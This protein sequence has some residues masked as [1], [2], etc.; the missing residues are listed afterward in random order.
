MK[1]RLITG[2]IGALLFL[3]ILYLGEFPYALLILMLALIGYD[4]F[5][6]MSGFK[7]TEGIAWTGYGLIL[8]WFSSSL[9]WLPRAFALTFE[10]ITWFTVFILLTV[11]VLSKNRFHF[12]RVA[13]LWIAA[14]YITL[15]F[16]YILE[17]RSL[18]NGFIWTLIVLFCTWA[19]DSGAYFTGRWV[20]KTKL[21]PVI[22]PKK[23]VEGSIGGIVWSIG[24]AIGFAFFYPDL[25]SFPKAITL[26][27]FIAIVGQLGDLIESAYKRHFNVKDSGS[28]LPGH[29]GV[30]DRVDSWIIVFPF[31]HLTN[32]LS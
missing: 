2:F 17:T 6:R 4:E 21:W 5:V 1:Q 23:T 25:L 29:G 8:I 3:W 32:F 10:Q 26:G 24:I 19:S 15:G 14:F 13:P 18:D 28:L 20:G 30:L 9:G 22:S 12:V 7:R 31:L 16:Y 11:T 27:L